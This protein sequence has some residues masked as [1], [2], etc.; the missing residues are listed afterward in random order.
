MS[1]GI[2]PATSLDIPCSDYANSSR[3]TAKSNDCLH[4]HHRCYKW[5][6]VVPRTD[7]Y[8]KAIVQAEKVDDDNKAVADA[9]RDLQSCSY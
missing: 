2:T 8:P 5:V 7:H 4:H 3:L 6:G 9:E 1:P